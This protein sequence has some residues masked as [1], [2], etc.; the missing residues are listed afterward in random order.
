MQKHRQEDLPYVPSY[1]LY[2]SMLFYALIGF[3]IIWIWKGSAF[4]DYLKDLFVLDSI[5]SIAAALAVV[6]AGQAYILATR[7]RLS[8]QLPATREVL[9]MKDLLQRN[10]LL[11]IPGLSLAS[12]VCEEILFR[13]ALLGLLAGW[14]GDLIACLIMTALFG[15]AHVPQYRGSWNAIIYVFVI[16]F[17][18]NLL[19][20]LYDQLWAPIALHFFN[21]LLNFTWMRHGIVKIREE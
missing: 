12:A 10:P 1:A 3:L 18:I 5:R 2:L 7:K 14:T 21:N 8:F 20:V 4:S 19:F 13:A 15:L 6:A 16:G 17:L 9:V 11:H